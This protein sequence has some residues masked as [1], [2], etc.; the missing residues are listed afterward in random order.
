MSHPIRTV[1]WFNG[2][3]REAAEFYCSLIPG[4]RIEGIF[5]S[6]N[7]GPDGR[8]RFQVVDLVLAGQPY[9]LLDAGPMFPL[10]ECVSIMLVLPTQA[11]ADR[12][13][14]ALTADGGSES[15]CGWLKDRF[16]LSWQIVPD[17]VMQLTMH[18][19][20]AISARAMAAMM[21]MGRLDLAAIQSAAAA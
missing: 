15:R 13:W 21:T 16:G 17:G 9:Q 12:L 5:T 2:R 14:S 18:P 20:P 11:E 6:D 7:G 8:M 4:S 10:S 19:D 3:S 1:L